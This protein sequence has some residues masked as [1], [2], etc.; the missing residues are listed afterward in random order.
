MRLILSAGWCDLWSHVGSAELF[1][2]P[3]LERVRDEGS[4]LPSHEDGDGLISGDELPRP[5][6]GVQKPWHSVPRS[7]LRR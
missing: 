6:C 4:V 1:S 7:W 2:G 5:N 3:A